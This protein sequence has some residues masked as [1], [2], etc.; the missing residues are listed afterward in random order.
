MNYATLIDQ[1]KTKLQSFGALRPEAW[2]RIVQLCQQTELKTG[3]SL[4]RKQ[5][6]LAYI[7][8]GLLK[9]YDAQNRTQPAI[10]NFNGPKQSIITRKHNQ[11]HYLKAAI[12]TTVWYLDF[13]DLQ[14]LYQEFKELKSIYD[15]L[16]AEYDEL[17]LFRMQL[18]ELPV[19]KRIDTFRL[20]FK[21]MLPYLKK[22]DMANYLHISY[23]YLVDNW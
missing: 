8:Q 7:A 23:A 11:N 1:F 6:T 21:P 22:K 13:E 4:I 14:K 17:L 10:I 9:E 2:E 20:I 18:L 16:I 15:A 12:S 19:Q 5:G 3:E